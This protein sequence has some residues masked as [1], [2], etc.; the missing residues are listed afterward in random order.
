MHSLYPV[1][2]QPQPCRYVIEFLECGVW[3]TLDEMDNYADV[4]LL[5][6]HYADIYGEDR[7][8]ISTP[9]NKLL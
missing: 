1:S 3:D 9:D 5:A 7:I 8:R 6:S 2:S 4:L